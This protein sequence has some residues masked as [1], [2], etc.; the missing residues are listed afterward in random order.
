MGTSE[1]PNRTPQLLTYPVSCLL[2]LTVRKGSWPRRVMSI[3]IPQVWEACA[4]LTIS[5]RCYISDCI[6]QF[7][8]RVNYYS[9]ISL[10]TIFLHVMMAE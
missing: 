4:F 1:S 7:A 10:N 8:L 6:L 2:L 9:S 3:L 5:N